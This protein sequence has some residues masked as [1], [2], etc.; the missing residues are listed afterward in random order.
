M[1]NPQEQLTI[2]RILK[3]NHAGEYGAI[4]IYR[5]QI[6]VARNRYPD[7]CAFLNETLGHEVRHCSLFLGAMPPRH[8]RPC[9]V[10]AF[11]GNGGWVLGFLTALLCRQGIW[12]CTAAVEAAVHRHLQDQLHFLRDRDPDLYALIA[13]IQ[14]EELMHLHHAEERLETRTLWSRLLGTMISKA[15]DAVIWLSTR[16]DSTA[17]A[18]ELEA[19]KLAS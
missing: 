2:A 6:W 5:A 16:G 4:R 19:A 15:T 12:I 18:K 13:S 8:A 14:D 1:V 3:V 10:M 7:V 17:M 11:W 9:R